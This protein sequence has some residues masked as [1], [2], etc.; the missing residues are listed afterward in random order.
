MFEV[1]ALEGCIE[2]VFS[3]V[4]AE[5][6]RCRAIGVA[7]ILFG[8]CESWFLKNKLRHYGLRYKRISI[9]GQPV[10]LNHIG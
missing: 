6:L 10:N 7:S 8:D 1:V 5:T 4:V 9:Y 2:A 3:C